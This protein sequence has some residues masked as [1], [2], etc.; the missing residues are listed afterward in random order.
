MKAHPC[1]EIF[2]MLGR[3]TRCSRL[4]SSMWLNERLKV[5][6][7]LSQLWFMLLC[8]PGIWTV[9]LWRQTSIILMSSTYCCWLRFP[10]CHC[11][12]CAGRVPLLRHWFLFFFTPPPLVMHPFLINQTFSMLFSSNQGMTL[13]QG[14]RIANRAWTPFS[15]RISERSQKTWRL[16]WLSLKQSCAFHE[17]SWCV[18]TRTSKKNWKTMLCPQ[19]YISSL[20]KVGAYMLYPFSCGLR[21]EPD[22]RSTIKSFYLVSGVM[23]CVQTP[24]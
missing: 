6:A 11:R 8:S 24:S 14:C 17:G 12:V 5:T 19:R 23:A 21:Q 2:P 16:T 1:G 22:T 4:L 13:K 15:V 20:G 18:W 9:A 7:S 10:W 3:Q